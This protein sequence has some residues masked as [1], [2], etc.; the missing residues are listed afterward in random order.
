MIVFLNARY[1]CSQS[2]AFQVNSAM[3]PGKY[4]ETY[5]EKAMKKRKHKQEVM[6]LPST[7]CR[8]LILKQERA[9]TQGAQEALEGTSYQTGKQNIKE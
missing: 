9:M 2:L 4:T 1:T 5:A 3:S 7:K 8:R 6:A